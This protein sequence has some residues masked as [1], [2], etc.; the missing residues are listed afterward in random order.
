MDLKETLR[1]TLLGYTGEGLNSYAYMTND[2]TMTRFAVIAVADNN[3]PPV[4]TNL[5]AHLEGD[6]IVIYHDVNNKPLVDALVQ[7]GVPRDKI[8]LAYA[9]EKIAPSN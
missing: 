1:E 9:G 8:I 6:L 2:N 7:N 3:I 4:F 5:I